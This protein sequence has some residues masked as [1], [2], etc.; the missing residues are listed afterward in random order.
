MTSKDPKMSKQG[1]AG[2]RR[3]VRLLIPQKLET[4]GGVENGKS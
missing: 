3:Q 2:K 1:N 4:I